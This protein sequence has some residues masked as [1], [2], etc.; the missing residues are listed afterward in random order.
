MGGICVFRERDSEKKKKKTCYLKKIYFN[1]LSQAKAKVIPLQ[2]MQN[3]KCV[4]VLCLSALL[5]GYG[6]FD[7]LVHHSSLRLVIES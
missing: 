3:I 4:F 1:Y 7:T 2:R 5:S 6:K